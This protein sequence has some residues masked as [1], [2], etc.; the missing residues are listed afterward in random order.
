M[1]P[2]K[3][4]C[5]IKNGLSW[6]NALIPAP[7]GFWVEPVT[8]ERFREQRR[9]VEGKLTHA[10]LAPECSCDLDSNARS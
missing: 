2:G 4:N 1:K 3:L 9:I 8:V 10:V 5:G 7:G 6:F